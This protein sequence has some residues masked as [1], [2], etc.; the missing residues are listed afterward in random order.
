MPITQGRV[1]V[2][3]VNLA[4]VFIRALIICLV[5][6][7]LSSVASAQ[8]VTGTISGVIKD[9]NGAVVPGAQVIARNTGTNSEAKTTTDG[10]GF[11]KLVNLVSSSY[12]IEVE[13]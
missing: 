9:P 2:N 7:L 10:T 13:A 8:G 4:R 12:V 1:T 5:L 6:G 11:Y 3:N